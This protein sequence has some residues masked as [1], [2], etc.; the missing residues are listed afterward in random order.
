ML[1]KLNDL[2]CQELRGGTWKDDINMTAI[3]SPATTY[4]HDG[5]TT[6]EKGNRWTVEYE[7]TQMHNTYIVNPGGQQY[8]DLGYQEVTISSGSTTM[9]NG[10]FKKLV[11]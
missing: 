8:Q 3:G 5:A 1:T 2:Q 6:S 7:T 9:N 10:Q 11:G 4:N